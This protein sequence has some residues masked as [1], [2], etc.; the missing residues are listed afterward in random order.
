VSLDHLNITKSYKI[1]NLVCDSSILLLKDILRHSG[2]IVHDIKRGSITLSYDPALLTESTLEQLLNKY[3]LEILRDRDEQLVEGIKIAVHELIHQL[4]NVNSIIQR[5]DYLVDKLGRSYQYL[6]K[7]FSKYEP[8][9]LEKYII[10]QKI[11]RVKTLIDQDELT[12]SEIAYIMEY[13]SVQYLSNQFKQITGLSVTEY[14]QNN[15]G[16]SN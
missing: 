13:S 7:L 15:R 10:L 14:K 12:L 16:G 1:R 5:S 3:H 2:F 11:E 9:T 4:N 8:Q 6:S